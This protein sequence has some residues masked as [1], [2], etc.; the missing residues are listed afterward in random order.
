MCTKKSLIH[1]CEKSCLHD[2]TRSLDL[3]DSGPRVRVRYREVNNVELSFCTRI[4]RADAFGS[5]GLFTMFAFFLCSPLLAASNCSRQFRLCMCSTGSM[6][7]FCWC[8]HFDFER[9]E[10]RNRQRSGGNQES[11]FTRILFTGRF[12]QES[13]CGFYFFFLIF[14]ICDFF[15]FLLLLSAVPCK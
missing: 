4:P 14:V 1:Y 6:L 9:N 8:F 7:C 3:Y 2:D 12:V 10:K 5:W 11:S 13:H 15:F